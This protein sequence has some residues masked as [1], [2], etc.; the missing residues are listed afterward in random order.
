VSGADDSAR[1]SDEN[2]ELR[3]RLQELEDTLHSIHSGDVDA[4]IVNNEIYTLESAHA[5]SNRLRQDVL[6]P[7]EDAVF[8]FD[9]HGHILHM[10]TAAA[11]QGITLQLVSAYRSYNYQQQLFQRKLDKGIQ[12]ALDVTTSR[13]LMGHAYSM[14]GLHS[15]YYD[16]D[17]VPLV[18]VVQDTVGRHDAFAMACASKYYDDIGYPGHVN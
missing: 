4:L 9:K 5:A 12:H 2:E 1:L 14:P 18:E 17:W 3:H 11:Q 7:R 8:A 16:Q 15:K 13:T 6:S 10:N